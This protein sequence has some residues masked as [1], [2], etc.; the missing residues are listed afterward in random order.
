MVHALWFIRSG[1]LC[2]SFSLLPKTETKT[3][4]QQYTDY[5]CV[6]AE[7][8]AQYKDNRYSCCWRTI[9]HVVENVLKYD[10][11][12]FVSFCREKLTGFRRSQKASET[13]RKNQATFTEKW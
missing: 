1:F 10:K 4:Q 12:Y 8:S 13:V 3:A 6:P 9:I 2:V 5:T 7:P 11:I